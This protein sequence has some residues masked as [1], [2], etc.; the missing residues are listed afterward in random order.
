MNKIIS[1][2]TARLN[3]LKRYYSGDPCNYGHDAER[4]VN[5]NGCVA[6]QA[7]RI[8]R[9]RKENPERWAAYRADQK[10]VER[11]RKYRE[12]NRETLSKK[13]IQWAR[14]NP[15]RL[16]EIRAK[17]LEKAVAY[18]REWR[19]A[20]PEL[21]RNHSKTW[22]D[23]NPAKVLERVRWR[24]AKLLRRTPS[25]ADRKAIADYYA[26]ARRLT[27]EMGEPHHVDHI[28]P[29]CGKLVSGLHVQNNLQVLPARENLRKFNHFE[30]DD[31]PCT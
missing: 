12:S 23:K 8:I 29:L 24:Q 3:N 9:S 18:N 30:P 1:R 11:R 6:C 31:F 15:D 27:I 10:T 7:E 21:A 16:K 5:S 2:E 19:N 17:R 13:K 20:K 22:R 14:A 25:W 26:E 28:I 4:Y